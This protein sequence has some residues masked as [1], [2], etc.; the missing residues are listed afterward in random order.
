[1]SSAVVFF[2][3]VFNSLRLPFRVLAFVCD[4]GLFCFYSFLILGSVL[5][6]FQT[7]GENVTVTF[8]LYIYIYIYTVYRM[9]KS[10]FLK[11][12][13]GGLNSGH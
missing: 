8:Q 7:T 10:N 6:S 9:S 4:C 3:V 11:H 13:S 5:L 1:M 12:R 2:V